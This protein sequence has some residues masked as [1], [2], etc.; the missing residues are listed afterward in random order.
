MGIIPTLPRQAVQAEREAKLGVFGRG[1][2]PQRGHPAWDILQKGGGKGRT[3]KLLVGNRAL[4]SFCACCPGNG[5]G[6]HE[7]C[8]YLI[9]NLY[10]NDVIN[11][12]RENML[13]M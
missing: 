13:G 6:G 9:Y 1:Q 3:W 5:T 12:K 11:L 2:K 8:K 10:N 7:I 4:L